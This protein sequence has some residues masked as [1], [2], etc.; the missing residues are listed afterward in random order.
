MP[1]LP[2]EPAL[3]SRG[4]PPAALT[5][6]ELANAKEA[7]DAGIKEIETLRKPPQQPG[8]R[9]LYFAANNQLTKD[10]RKAFDKVELALRNIKKALDANQALSAGDV[11]T[12]HTEMEAAIKAA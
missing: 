7:V 8:G 5:P 1:E 9:G 3:L 11:K 6:T 4:P 12:F 2:G 10:V